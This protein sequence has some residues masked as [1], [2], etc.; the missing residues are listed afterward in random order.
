MVRIVIVGTALWFAG[1]LV[2]L[3]FRGRLADDGNEVWLWTCLAGGR[4]RP[5]RAGAGP[6]RPRRLPPGTGLARR[7]VLCPAGRGSARGGV[8]RSAAAPAR[9]RYSAGGSCSAPP[10]EAE[11]L[12][13][14]EVCL[15]PLAAPARG[16]GP[17]PPAASA[18]PRRPRQSTSRSGGCPSRWRPRRGGGPRPPRRRAPR[19]RPPAGPTRR[20]A[21]PARGRP[22]AGVPSTWSVPPAGHHGTGTPPTVSRSCTA[23]VAAGGTPPHR[24]AASAAPGTSA[25]AAV[26]TGAASGPRSP[27]SSEASGRS[28]RSATGPA[29]APAGTGTRSPSSGSRC[30]Q[31]EHHRPLPRHGAVRADPDPVRRLGP[32]LQHQR[33]P[34]VRDPER[35]P[36]RRPVRVAEPVEQ[37]DRPVRV[38]AARRPA[39]SGRRPAPA[40]RP[41]PDRTGRPGR[42]RPGARSSSGRRPPSVSC[43]LSHHVVYE[44]TSAR[45]PSASATVTVGR[46]SSAASRSSAR[47][48]PVRPDQVEVAHRDQL[49]QPGRQPL[50]R[51]PVQHGLHPVGLAVQVVAV[52]VRVQLDV[53]GPEQREGPQHAD[54]GEHVGGPTGRSTARSSRPERRVRVHHL[55]QRGAGQQQLAGRVPVAVGRPAAPARPARAARR[56]PAGRRRPGRAPR[57][58][59][60][61]GP[62]SSY[63]ALDRGPHPLVGEHAAGGRRLGAEP[64]QQRV[65][66]VAGGR[67]AGRARRPPRPAGRVGQQRA[68]HAGARSG[69]RRAGPAAA[70]SAS[71]SGTSA[72]AAYSSR[73]QAGGRSTPETSSTTSAVDSRRTPS[74]VRAAAW[75]RPDQLAGSSPGSRSASTA[76]QPVGRRV[77][78]HRVPAPAP[79]PPAGSPAGSAGSAGSAGGWRQPGGVPQRGQHRAADGRV[80]LGGGQRRPRHQRQQRRRRAAA[81]RPA[82][83][84]PARRPPRAGRSP[85]RG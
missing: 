23:T 67:P 53:R 66:G 78:H 83:R 84:T 12:A 11:Q 43:V 21:R 36:R 63:E 76:D 35:R 39:R 31:V 3:P 37:V 26:R 4:A 9:G 71:R 6:P 65:R 64:L 13:P 17:T 7:L 77:H 25:Q 72:S 80:Q 52:A 38:G 61:P 60:G 68:A 85:G 8:P 15:G 16:R 44:G 33:Q 40:G 5:D 48:P 28:S 45:P 19:P 29:A 41:A 22:R 27:T 18:L 73:H 81:P 10:A 82:P 70:A 46:T 1:F 30:R 14:E 42:R 58:R 49:G 51:E 79:A 32:V 54:G 69:R 75:P 59:P 57:P 2:L 55:R 50:R 74:A 20:A 24:S 47:R 34:G 56:A 62:P